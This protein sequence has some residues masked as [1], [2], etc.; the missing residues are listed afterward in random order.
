MLAPS[1]SKLPLPNVLSTSPRRAFI[2]HAACRAYLKPNIPKKGEPWCDELIA[3]H[4]DTLRALSD[5]GGDTNPEVDAWVV[6]SE[7]MLLR[8]EWEEAVRVFERVL[9][10]SGRSDRDVSFPFLFDCAGC[11]ITQVLAR[12]QKAQRLLKQSRQKDY[13]KVLGVARDAD[14]KTIK[15]AFVSL[16]FHY[17]SSS[18]PH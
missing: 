16:F 5:M 13:Y 8:E 18:D 12:L 9:E 4:E 14:A 15:K 3:M 2:L 7:A 6:K 11:W 17:A 10:S 1:S